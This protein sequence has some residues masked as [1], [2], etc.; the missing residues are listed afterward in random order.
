MQKNSF[1]LAD[2]NI[3]IVDTERKYQMNYDEVRSRLFQGIKL[4]R[5]I[6]NSKN[7]EFKFVGRPRAIPE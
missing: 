2:T 6:H 5:I 7:A 1:R 4:S 3:Y